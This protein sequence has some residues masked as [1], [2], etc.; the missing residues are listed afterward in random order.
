MVEITPTIFE[1]DL[2]VRD[3]KFPE[4]LVDFV[5]GDED[6]DDFLQYEALNACME[7]TSKGSV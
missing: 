7:G 6:L 2:F 5:C 4:E 3:L 1:A